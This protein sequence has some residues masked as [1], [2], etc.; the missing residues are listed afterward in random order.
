MRPKTLS[1][2]RLHIAPQT[3]ARFRDRSG[4]DGILIDPAAP[5]T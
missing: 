5:G 1:I 2:E 3:L 4:V